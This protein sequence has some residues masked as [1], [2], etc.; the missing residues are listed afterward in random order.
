MFS[1]IVLICSE[2]EHSF[3]FNLARGCMSNGSAHTICPECDNEIQL[4]HE[5]TF[6]CGS[7]GVQVVG[8][9]RGMHV[10]IAGGAMGLLVDQK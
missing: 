9:T 1:F 10:E 6:L 4:I 3:T 8:A 7:V 2:C 5:K